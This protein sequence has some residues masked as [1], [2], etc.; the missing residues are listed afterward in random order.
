[1]LK[2]FHCMQLG[3]SP[4]PK[5]TF[6][7]IQKRHQTRLFPSRRR[8]RVTGRWRTAGCSPARRRLHGRGADGREGGGFGVGIHRVANGKVFETWLA[9]DA[10]GLMRQ[11]GAA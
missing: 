10:L 7:V 4:M 2:L 6:L 8:W 5:L 11:L 3:I 1:M 9:Y